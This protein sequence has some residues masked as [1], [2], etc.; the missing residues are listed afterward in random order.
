MFPL[1]NLYCCGKDAYPGKITHKH[2]CFRQKPFAFAEAE[3]GYKQNSLWYSG[4]DTEYVDRTD[5]Q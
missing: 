3:S 2:S 1:T 5:F 4:N